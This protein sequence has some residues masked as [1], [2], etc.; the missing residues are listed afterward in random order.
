MDLGYTTAELLVSSQS[1]YGIEVIGPVRDDPSWQAKHHPKFASSN[2]KIDW[3]KEIAIC[4]QG[5]QS[6]AWMNKIDVSGQPVVC[7]RFSRSVCS[8]C[9]EASAMHPCQN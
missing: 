3:D 6:K 4:P 7:I 2:F 9:T 8:A 1:K 5:H